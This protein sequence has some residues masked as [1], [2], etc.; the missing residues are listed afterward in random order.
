[1]T[2]APRP[3][4]PS[5][6]GWS[7]DYVDELYQRFQQDPDS[8]SGEERMF[9]LGFDL[10]QAGELRLPGSGAPSA[11]SGAPAQAASNGK[12]V[13]T[14]SKG[15]PAGRASHFQ[16]IV[17]DLIGAFRLHGHLAAQ[18]DPF[19]DDREPPESLSLA[20][21]NLSG[22]DLGGKVDGSGVGFDGEVTLRELVDRLESI[23]CST[24]GVEFGHIED[25]ERR[26][27]LFERFETA[28]GRLE[29]DRAKKQHLLELLTRS[30]MFERFLGK[31]Y[32]GEKRFS[33]EGSESLI[34]LLDQ[35]LETATELDAEE[36]VLGMAHRGRLN[37]LNNTL[38]KT[39]EQMFTEFEESWLEDYQD[40]GGDVKYHRGYSGTRRY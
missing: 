29:L 24:I 30:E 34:P 32:P 23:Y 4:R 12:A 26:G 17:D 14:P 1:M 3:T 5:I 33:L 27:W 21:H 31:R 16:A 35:L 18:L 37:V 19:G 9:F 20:F 13:V 39:Y 40:G 11:S 15:Q 28:G 25:E 36:V 38:G 10:A 7:A 8:L 22:D 6:N 2:T